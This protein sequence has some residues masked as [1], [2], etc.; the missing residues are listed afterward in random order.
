M[1]LGCF[2]IVQN[3]PGILQPVSRQFLSEGFKLET[4][5]APPPL[6]AIRFPGLGEDLQARLGE[7]PNMAIWDAIAARL[8]A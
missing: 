2:L 3:G 6:L 8:G 7:M 1:T 4:L 5:W